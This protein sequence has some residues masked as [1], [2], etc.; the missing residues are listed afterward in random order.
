MNK[1]VRI[2][3]NAYHVVNQDGDAIAY[4][5]FYRT[6][7]GGKIYVNSYIVVG[8]KETPLPHVFYKQLKRDVESGMLDISKYA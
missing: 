5:H 3:T 4:I 6:W 1:L 2:G 8:D 7:K